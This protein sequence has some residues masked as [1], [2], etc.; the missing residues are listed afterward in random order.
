[1]LPYKG[2]VFALY[3]FQFSVCVYFLEL[4]MQ[5]FESGFFTGDNVIEKF[6][7]AIF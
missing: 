7:I 2:F 4:C 6:T 1:M 5:V 3:G